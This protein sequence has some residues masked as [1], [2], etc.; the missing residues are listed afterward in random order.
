MSAFCAPRFSRSADTLALSFSLIADDFRLIAVFRFRC[1]ASG[2]TAA[3]YA[4]ITPLFRH[5]CRRRL[6]L[7][8]AIALA[9]RR[10]RCRLAAISA[11]AAGLMRARAMLFIFMSFAALRRCRLLLYFR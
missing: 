2:A 4:A 5:F 7:L 11:A 3:D 10:R 1:A 9:F 8:I 6:R